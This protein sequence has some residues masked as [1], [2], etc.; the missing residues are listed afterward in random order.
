MKSIIHAVTAQSKVQESD[1]TSRRNT[2]SSAAIILSACFF[3]V[4]SVILIALLAVP[5]FVLPMPCAVRTESAPFALSASTDAPPEIVTAMRSARKTRAAWNATLDS[6]YVAEDVP[7]VVRKNALTLTAN[8]AVP[9]FANRAYLGLPS[10]ELALHATAEHASS[11]LLLSV[12]LSV[13]RAN[14]STFA[15]TSLD[16]AVRYASCAPSTEPVRQS[17]SLFAKEDKG[18]ATNAWTLPVVESAN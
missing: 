10:A 11:L 7:S 2:T 17:A 1:A 15:L 4:V 18:V 12:R 16:V 14:F 9:D 8:N 13:R 6:S 5:L 3:S